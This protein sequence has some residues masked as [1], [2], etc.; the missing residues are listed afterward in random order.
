V[1]AVGPAVGVANPPGLRA[2]AAPALA[3]RLPAAPG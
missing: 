2:P 3:V 1:N